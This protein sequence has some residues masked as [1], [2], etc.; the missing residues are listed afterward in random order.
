MSITKSVSPEIVAV[1]DYITYTITVCNNGPYC[2]DEMVI[3]D[4]LSPELR[5]IEG[6]LRFNDKPIAE[7]IIAGIKFEYL[8]AHSKMVYTITFDAEVIYEG[9]ANTLITYSTMTFTYT[10]HQTGKKQFG[11]E[12]SNPCQL[13]VFRPYLEVVKCPQ[14]QSI[15]Y[16]ETVSYFITLYNS[17]D[18]L[19]TNVLVKDTFSPVLEIIPG[20][21][22]LDGRVIHIPHLKQGINVTAIKQGETRVISFDVMVKGGTSETGIGSQTGAMA[23]YI[24]PD[25]TIGVKSFDAYITEIEINLKCFKKI[26]LDKYLLIPPSSAAIGDIDEVVTSLQ[27]DNQYISETLEGMSHE[28]EV[29]TGRQVIVSGT[30][31]LD[32]SYTGTGDTQSMHFIHYELPFSTYM[33]LP[34]DYKDKSAIKIVG[35]IEDVRYRINSSN[36]FYITLN[37]YLKGEVFR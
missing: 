25:D 28:R 15:G 33:V 35:S 1:G 11:K 5:F 22:M 18:L 14:R 37:I 17:G 9:D 3:S 23:T 27:I 12:Q 29:A 19:L 30:A 2:L 4:I 16:G 21:I 26:I 20:T 36:S 6:S 32:M 8:P 31:K 10:D 7:D 13:Q 24:L 34:L